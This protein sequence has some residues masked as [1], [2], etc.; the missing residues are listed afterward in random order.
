MWYNVDEVGYNKISNAEFVN[1]STIQ[2][3][4]FQPFKSDSQFNVKLENTSLEVSDVKF[5]NKNK[6]ATLTLKNPFDLVNLGKSCTVEVAD[7][8]RRDILFNNLYE[9]EEFVSQY[10][11]DEKLGAIYSTEK[12]TFKLWAPTASSVKLNLFINPDCAISSV[13]DSLIILITS[14]I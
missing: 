1:P 8:G 3:N 2:V 4:A 13:S 5:S 9:S 10:T 6:T 12:T 7:F 14:S 11:T